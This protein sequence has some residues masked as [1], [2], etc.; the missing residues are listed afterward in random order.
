[1]EIR[2]ERKEMMCDEV[3]ELPGHSE[4]M[5]DHHEPVDSLHCARLAGTR[6]NCVS[7]AILILMWDRHIRLGVSR[8]KHCGEVFLLGQ[9]AFDKSRT[10]SRRLQERFRTDD[11]D[12]N[13]SDNP[14]AARSLHHL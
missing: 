13:F 4:T 1:M 2:C 3:A 5:G 9:L 10:V 7:L 14:P 8:A 11:A 6:A 12:R